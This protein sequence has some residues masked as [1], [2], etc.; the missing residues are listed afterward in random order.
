MKRLICK[1]LN[2]ETISYIFFGILTTLVNYAVF[3]VFYHFT[4]ID[5]LIY[6][7]L[8]WIISVLFA[9]I[10]NKLFVFSS[11]SFA[12][13][14]VLKEFVTFVTARL[15]SLFFETVFMAVTIKFLHMNELLSKIICSIFVVIF[16]YF[17]SKFLIFNKNKGES[18]E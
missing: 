15:L 17:A 4:N 10:T 2:K 6:N 13:D 12:F 9:F 11:K 18:H 8:A 16:N 14:R 5:T 1:L 3:Y 7:T